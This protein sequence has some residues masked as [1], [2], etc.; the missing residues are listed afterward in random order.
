[1]R[2]R[3]KKL[4]PEDAVIEANGIV[5][6]QQYARAFCIEHAEAFIALIS[7]YGDKNA[8]EQLDTLREAFWA[9]AERNPEEGE[10]VLKLREKLKAAPVPK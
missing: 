1:M 2:K 7:T 3:A 10:Y 5:E 6:G 8:H 4:H 9:V